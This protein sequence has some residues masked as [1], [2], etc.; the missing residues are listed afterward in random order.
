MVVSPLF[1]CCLFVCLVSSRCVRRDGGKPKP[2]TNSVSTVAASVS[3]PFRSVK[4][5]AL[6]WCTTTI[7]GIQRFTAIGHVEYC[8]TDSCCFVL[9]LSL[10]V[11]VDASSGAPAGLG[12]IECVCVCCLVLLNRYWGI[13]TVSDLLVEIEYGIRC[14]GCEKWTLH[15]RRPYS[16]VATSHRLHQK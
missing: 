5:H 8:Q 3:C 15:R 9:Q 10:A 12:D 6:P 14:L 1:V 4:L 2:G 7:Y 16:H 11:S 13:V